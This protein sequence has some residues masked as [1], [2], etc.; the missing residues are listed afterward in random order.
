MYRL[1][2]TLFDFLIGPY[3]IFCDRPEIYDFFSLKLLCVRTYP[4]IVL[5]MV[6]MKQDT[7]MRITFFILI[8]A[9]LA[10]VILPVMAGGGEGS[11]P[12][13][14]SSLSSQP[15]PQPPKPAQ[16]EG[17]FS[18][19]M[20]SIVPP[21]FRK[22]SPNVVAEKIRVHIVPLDSKKDVIQG[23][24]ASLQAT[25]TEDGSEY[26]ETHKVSCETA[27]Y[28]HVLR[29][30]HESCILI[31]Y[32]DPDKSSPDLE[33]LSGGPGELQDQKFW[34]KYVDVQSFSSYQVMCW[35]Q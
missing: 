14:Y 20:K 30:L 25:I 17:R 5:E 27:H 15:K 21:F 22:E 23:S 28:L 19:F 1:L 34:P 3:I 26:T 4:R 12:P 35:W 31:I 6:T 29:P 13:P 10:G 9:F 7:N 11:D 33:I 32:P 18:T 8:T 2:S 24:G 16:P